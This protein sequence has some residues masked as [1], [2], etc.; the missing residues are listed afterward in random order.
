MA[1]YCTCIIFFQGHNQEHYTGQ[2][3]ALGCGALANCS[4][5]E[6]RQPKSQIVPLPQ[7]HLLLVIGLKYL[8]FI[9]AQTAVWLYW[10][11]LFFSSLASGMITR[12]IRPKLSKFLCYVPL[13]VPSFIK[14]MSSVL[15]PK[16]FTCFWLQHRCM[17]L[18]AL[19]LSSASTNDQKDIFPLIKLKLHRQIPGFLYRLLL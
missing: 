5:N 13:F 12:K 8:P 16:S 11:L 7:H 10:Y 17:Y 9:L 3:H 15:N 19:L 14:K 4:R 2:L 1:R 18:G 6:S